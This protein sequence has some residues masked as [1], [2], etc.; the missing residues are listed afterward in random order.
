MAPS[1]TTAPL[2]LTCAG[3]AVPKSF[4]YTARGERVEPRGGV[5][6]IPASEFRGAVEAARSEPRVLN[7]YDFVPLARR[8]MR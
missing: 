2:P 6:W 4:N 7:A 8:S 3:D 5:Y 1:K